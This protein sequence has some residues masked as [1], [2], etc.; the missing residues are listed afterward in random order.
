M[1]FSE[2]VFKRHPLNDAFVV[3]AFADATQAV[4]KFPNGYGVSVITGQGFNTDPE[5]P[6]ELAVLKGDQLDY[7]TG[8]TDDVL[9]HLT[10]EDVEKI[11]NRV[12]LL[13]E[14]FDT[15]KPDAA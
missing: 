13:I 15:G 2:L 9:G 12:E 5:H 4:H 7:T 6:Y 11:L 14:D 3:A 1:K 10:A 8:I